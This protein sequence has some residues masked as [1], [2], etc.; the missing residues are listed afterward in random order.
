MPAFIWEARTRAGEVKNGTMV[1]DT[2]EAVQQRLRQQS[3]QPQSVK[4]QPLQIKLKLPQFGS[5][6]SSKDLVLF[7]R[8][9]STMIDAGLPLVQ[10][11]DI[12]GN[13]NDNPAFKKV[14][15]DLKSTV[16]TGTTFAEALKK[17]P[18]VF[19]T[20]FVNLV[21]AG[22]TGGILDTI[23][24][25]LSA[26]I[27]K[28]IK[29]VKQIKGA[30][31][32]PLVVLSVSFAVVSVLLLFVIPTFEKMFKDMGG[33]L[34]GLTQGLIDIS[35]WLQAWAIFIFPA[36]AAIVVAGIRFKQTKRGTEIFDKTILKAPVFGD[37]VRKVAVA[38]FTSTMGTMLS[39]GV[40]ILDSLDIVARSAGNTV[41]EQGILFVRAK[42]S[43]G[44]TMA[45]PLADTK[46]FPPMV[47]QM[48]AV[49]ESTGALDKML[50]KIADFYEEEVDE[51]VAAM[52]S[53]IEP[54]MMVFLGG[55]L[56][57]MM[58][59][60]YLPIFTMAGSLK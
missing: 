16:E 3:L 31:T 1:A 47:V 45:Q 18:K 29:L 53:L 35:Q 50:T 58:I 32:Y 9:F 4:K 12:L 11:L 57:T 19:D 43:E 10:C 2:I 56:G 55:L 48:I 15:L 30:M 14:L 37:I 24:N 41:V 20:L 5:G 28:N 38:R 27:E 44:K 7:T 33:T 40:P 52:T 36:I 46:I 13:Q 21:A 51:A 22:E 25:R 42:I 49:G 8:Q 54:F 39:S 26:Y 23:M 6:V 17:H 34:P 59:A 60:M